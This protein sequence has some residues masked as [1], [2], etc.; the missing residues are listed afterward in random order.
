MSSPHSWARVQHVTVTLT[1]MAPQTVCAHVH[2]LQDRLKPDN[3]NLYRKMAEVACAS[4]YNGPNPGNINKLVM[5]TGGV[6]EIQMAKEYDQVVNKGPESIRW[7][8]ANGRLNEATIDSRLIDEAINRPVL[9]QGVKD[10]VWVILKE[11][12]ARLQS[13]GR[14]D[15]DDEEPA[16]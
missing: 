3:S 11:T 1:T 12:V 8:A 13:T 16:Y 2:P 6:N 9:P 14:D 10:Q 7:A 15:F 4:R 5:I